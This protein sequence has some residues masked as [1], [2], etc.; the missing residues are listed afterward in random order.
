M[1]KAHITFV[2][3]V[4]G[5]I[6]KIILIATLIP[7]KG[8]NGYLYAVLIGQLIITALDIFAVIRNVQFGFDS[9]NSIVKPGIIVA[10]TSLVLKLAYN[11]AKKMT[12]INEVIILLSFCSILCVICL[13]LLFLSKAVSR[14]DF[15]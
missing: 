13:A 8:I 15:R 7:S 4:I 9:I 6:S 5:T 1:G 14:K 10:A 2:N 3:S 11:S 12:H